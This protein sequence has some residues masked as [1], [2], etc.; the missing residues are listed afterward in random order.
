[1]E[2]LNLAFA[3][4]FKNDSTGRIAISEPLKTDGASFTTEQEKGRIGHD[5]TFG[6]EEVSQIFY[7]GVYEKADNPLQLPDGTVI[8][9]NCM[10]LPFLLKYYSIYG[11]ESEVEFIITRNSVDFVVGVLDFQLA[12]TDLRT[13]F[14]TKVVQETKRAQIKRQQDTKIDLFSDKNL[15]LQ[16]ITPCTTSNILLKAKPIN[17]ISTWTSVP[18]GAI[19][20]SFTNYNAGS[21]FTTTQRAGVNICKIPGSYGIENSLSYISSIYNIVQG[22]GAYVPN[23]GLN[24]TYIEAVEE[25]TNVTIEVTNLQAYTSQLIENGSISSGVTCTSGDGRVRFLVLVGADYQIPRIVGVMYEKIFGFSQSTPLEYLPTSLTL[26]IPLIVAGERVYIYMESTSSATFSGTNSAIANYKVFAVMNNC[27]IKISGTSTAID[28]VIKGVRYVDGLKQI[29]KAINGMDVIAPRF[30]TGGQFYDQFAFSGKLIRQIANKPFY[31]EFKNWYSDLQEVNCDYQINQQNVFIGHERDYYPNKEILVLETVPNTETA[32]EFNEKLC[33]NKVEYKY[34]NFAQNRDDLNTT[35]AVHTEGQWLVPNKQVENVKKIEIDLIR[36]YEL[37]EITRKQNVSTKETTSL[38]EDDK[39]FLIY[40]SELAPNTVKGF[41][42]LLQMRIDADGNLQ[43]LNGTGEQNGAFNWQL[44]GF[45]TAPGGSFQITQG[46]NS[47]VYSIVNCTP[48][49]LTLSGAPSFQGLAV[50]SV[51]YVLNNVQYQDWTSQL[52]NL[53]TGINAPNDTC[54][55]RSTPTGN[56]INHFGEYLSACLFYKGSDAVI[57]NTYYKSNGE[58]KIQYNGGQIIKMN[59]PILKSQLASAIITPEIVTRKAVCSFENALAY[60]QA[61]QTIDLVTGTIGG[62][63]RTWDANG[64]VVLGHSI[65]DDFVWLDNIMTFKLEVRAENEFLTVSKFGA[66][67]VYIN[68]VGFS[69]VILSKRW[70]RIFG[71]Y[72]TLLDMNEIPLTNPTRF[73]KVKVNGALSAS[74][75]SLAIALS[76]L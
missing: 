48:T 39:L 38:S 43:I 35:D 40:V 3:L 52:F 7:E 49:V 10:G 1:M 44:L 28:S 61:M 26:N 42:R 4:N 31:A 58:L 50:I 34:K 69:D 73:N 22:T 29:P 12:K 15:D 8:Y 18:E 41:T 46:S 66:A 30:D 71:D 64:R 27:N 32:S 68:E 24:F 33:V 25:L 36:D 65:K 75:E 47:G 62:Y 2:N 57:S 16:A 13:Y 19:G 55:L 76:G 14:E 21:A 67:L 56:L 5:V 59:A 60:Y 45:N 63:I 53:I 54:N 20:F 70:F 51:Q 23:D 72:V 37:I 74:A 9:Q 11:F 17:Q 6:N